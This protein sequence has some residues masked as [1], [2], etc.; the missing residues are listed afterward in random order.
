MLDNSMT[1]GETLRTR[2]YG[3]FPTESTR[4][5][6][7]LALTQGLPLAR[8]YEL[9]KSF[10]SQVQQEQSSHLNQTFINGSFINELD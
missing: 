1:N 6:A 9:A 8:Q 10:V 4:I 7:A 2:L 3:D 5:D